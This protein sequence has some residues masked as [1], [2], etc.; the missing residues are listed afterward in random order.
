MNCK[1]AIRDLAI[2]DGRRAGRE[3]VVAGAVTATP[4]LHRR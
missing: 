2:V 1:H 4:H 3:M